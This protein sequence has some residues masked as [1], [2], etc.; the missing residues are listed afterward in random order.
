MI[1]CLG[2]GYVQGTEMTG[3]MYSNDGPYEMIIEHIDQTAHEQP[4]KAIEN[5]FPITA[6]MSICSSGR[7]NILEGTKDFECHIINKPEEEGKLA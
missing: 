7:V 1:D 2:Y 3:N 4:K 6:M 5:E